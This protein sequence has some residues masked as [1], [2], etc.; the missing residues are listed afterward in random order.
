MERIA[1]MAIFL[2]FVAF[3]ARDILFRWHQIV[4]EDNDSYAKSDVKK[5]IPSINFKPQQSGPTLK[6]L[7]CYSCGYKRAFDEYSNLIRDRF[8]QLAI[9]GENYTPG[10]ARNKL[11]QWLTVLKLT[12]MAFLMANINP[13]NWFGLNTPQVWHWMTQHKVCILFN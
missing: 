9:V 12:I 5:E 6:I 13:F 10:F 7:Y 11:V 4:E 1:F 3:T 2:V 8:P